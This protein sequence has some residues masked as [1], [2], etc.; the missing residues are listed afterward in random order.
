[1]A[2]HAVRCAHREVRGRPG[3]WQ[4]WP[5]ALDT[6][7]RRARSSSGAFPSRF[8]VPASVNDVLSFLC[9][10]ASSGG[11]KCWMAEMRCKFGSE[12][13]TDLEI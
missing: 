4:R 7:S 3:A 13:E 9:W 2:A 11:M 12:S 1:M 6:I 10:R 5:C 8:P